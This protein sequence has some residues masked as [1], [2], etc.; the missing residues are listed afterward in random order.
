[1]ILWGHKG[2]AMPSRV[3]GESLRISNGVDVLDIDSQFVED[4]CGEVGDL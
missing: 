4:M 2:K 3:P 1:M